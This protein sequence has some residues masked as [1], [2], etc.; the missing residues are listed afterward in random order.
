MTEIEIGL[1]SKKLGYVP[2]FYW[3][4]GVYND[5]KLR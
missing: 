4:Q 3:R 1:M 5:G 2:D